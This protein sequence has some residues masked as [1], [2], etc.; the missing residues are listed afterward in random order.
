MDFNEHTGT[1]IDA[2][3]HFAKGKLTVDQI[4]PKDLIAK[5]IVVDITEQTLKDRDYALTIDDFKNWE[6]KHG[7]IPDGSIVFI[8]TGLGKYWGNYEKYMGKEKKSNGEFHWPG[9]ANATAQWLVDKRKIKGVGTD[10][11]SYDVGPSETFPAH[12]IFLGNNIYCLETVANIEKLPV[13]G[14]VVY[15][16]PM[17]IK[18]GTGGPT[19]VIAKTKPAGRGSHLTSSILVIFLS[20]LLTLLNHK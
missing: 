19:R 17:K 14:A 20:I 4:P 18:G 15:V 6:E 7:T 13:K 16:M 11:R 9:F 10:A 2:P 1:H 3:V 5:A 12:Q 8:L